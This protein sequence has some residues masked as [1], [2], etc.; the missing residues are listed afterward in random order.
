MSRELVAVSQTTEALQ[1]EF[2]I[3]RRILERR[4]T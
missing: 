4:R 3:L 1:E 2:T